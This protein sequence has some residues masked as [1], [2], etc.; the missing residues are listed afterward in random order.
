MILFYDTETTG[1]PDGKKPLDEQPRI[2]QLG[3][4]LAYPDRRE[5][6]RLDTILSLGTV[7]TSVLSDWTIGRDGKGGAAAIHGVSPEI[8]EKIGMTE[9]IA[10]EAFMDLVAVADVIVGHNHISFDNKIVTNVVRRVMGRPDADPFEGKSMFDT[11]VA[12]TPLM[13][14]P[15]RQG[16]YRKPKLIDLHKHLTGEGFEDAHTAIADVQA[17]RRCYYA[18]Q[19]MVAA[20]LQEKTA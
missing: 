19:D 8:S 15:S 9:A 16:G 10:I 2:V 7:P 6:A 4:I 3:A 17:T 5:A 1:F 12:G 14:L 18:M 13:K 11:I 20:K